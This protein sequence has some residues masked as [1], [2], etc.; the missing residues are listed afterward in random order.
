MQREEETAALTEDGLRAQCQR[1][2]DI[3]PR[4]YPA[5]EQDSE[6]P[7]LLGGADNWRGA[8]GG[9]R[10]KRGERAVDLAPAVVGDNYSGDAESYGGLCVLECMNP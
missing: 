7:R 3:A 5:V 6:R 2:D 9:E 8:Y 1:L 10:V 4:A